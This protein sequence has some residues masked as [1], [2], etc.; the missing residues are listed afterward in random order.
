MLTKDSF[1]A[2]RI[3]LFS[4]IAKGIKTYKICRIPGYQRPTEI[5]HKVQL[6]NLGTPLAMYIRPVRGIEHANAD[7]VIPLAMHM[8]EPSLEEGQFDL[9]TQGISHHASR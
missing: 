2:K 7:C 3:A 6:L 4:A 5:T 8:Y 1:S 9:A